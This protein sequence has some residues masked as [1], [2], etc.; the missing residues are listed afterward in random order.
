MKNKDKIAAIIL[1][2]K[3][4]KGLKNKNIVN[5]HGKPLIFY[6]IQAAKI[7]KLVQRTFVCTDS[8]KISRI[9]LAYGAE[10]PFLRDSK[11]AKDHST[12]EE[13]LYNFL[14]NLKKKINYRPDIVVY[15]QPTDIFREKTLIDK[16][17]KNLIKYKK[18]DSSFVVSKSHKNFWFSEKQ[19]FK[20]IMINRSKSKIY[21]P[22]QKKQ[23]IYREDTGLA[24]A[25]RFKTIKK[26]T[27]IGQKVKV[28]INPEKLPMIDIHTKKDVKIA[29]VLI[30]KFKINPNY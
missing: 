4:S 19:T 2:R 11:F 12:S 13:A 21:L 20:R 14:I 1:A 27:R 3:N 29:E 6:S 17:I 10:V 30:K 25:T 16:C 7:S 26:N 24:L 15:L 5:L 22:R 23:P 28:V 18:I 9:S 8:E